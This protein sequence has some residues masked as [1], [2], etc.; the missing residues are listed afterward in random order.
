MLDI[1]ED[2]VP[3]ESQA[4]HVAEY[5]LRRIRHELVV[6]RVPVHMYRMCDVHV[7]RFKDEVPDA[8]NACAVHL[9]LHERSHATEAGL[10]CALWIIC[11]YDDRILVLASGV[12]L[13]T[14]K[15][16]ELALALEK[17]REVLLLSQR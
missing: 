9:V 7:G 5:A 13:W 2:Y 12:N 14:Y 6:Y 15:R 17:A 10:P 11:A 4:R 8:P 3:G 16:L 1:Q